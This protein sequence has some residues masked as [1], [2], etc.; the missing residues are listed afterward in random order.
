MRVTESLRTPSSAGLQAR[1]ANFMTRAD[2]IV[3]HPLAGER[4]T[5]N[6]MLW[7]SKTSGN[8][9]KIDF[10][11]ANLDESSWAYLA[12]LMRPVV[13][14]QED[15][16]SIESVTVA[17]EREHPSV[18]GGS[19]K[20]LRRGLSAWHKQ[21]HVALLPMGEADV[22]LPEGETRV[23]ALWT[24]A[25]GTA[26]VEVS[27]GTSDAVMANVFLNGC[28]WHGDADKA[29]RYEEASPFM[30]NY[31]AKCAEMRT[32]DG[33]RFVDGLRQWI[34]DARADGRDF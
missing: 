15:S 12:T 6:L 26:P 28:L 1:V 9:A 30:K 23:D 32:L 10:D 4:P 14:L 16:T 31:M 7:F 20:G 29:T 22:P 11:L 34:L 27:D 25:V 8:L 5:W 13:F 21:V 19:L 18:R 2:K 33:V 3:A 24:G 17:I